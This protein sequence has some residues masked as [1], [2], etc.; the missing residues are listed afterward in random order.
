MRRAATENEIAS[1]IALTTKADLKRINRYAMAR[2]WKLGSLAMGE[3]AEDFISS[4]ILSTLEG[5]RSW[6]PEE[7]CWAD[8]LIDVIG[9]ITNHRF[10]STKART[11]SSTLVEIG[12][13]LALEQM[14]VI[15][16]VLSPEAVLQQK[17]R[18][19]NAMRLLDTLLRRLAAI[20]EAEGVICCKSDGM[21]ASEIQQLLGLS[22]NRFKAVDRRIR[23][24]IARLKLDATPSD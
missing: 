12:S 8:H 24:E 15:H 22:E 10:H 20:P 4:A 7:K 6:Y 9:S 11:E 2:T 18:V 21:S 19:H 23:R 14:P 3:S 1:A 16:D 17:Q 13:D 5:R